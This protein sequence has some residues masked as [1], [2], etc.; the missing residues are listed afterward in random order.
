MTKFQKVFYWTGQIAVIVL[1]GAW[2]WYAEF[3]GYYIRTS[4]RIAEPE[5]GY[6]IP[7]QTKGITLYIAKSDKDL[8]KRLMYVII[9]SGTVTLL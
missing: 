6:T 1:V 7:Y 9:G 3:E 5:H 2:F 8:Q 4:P